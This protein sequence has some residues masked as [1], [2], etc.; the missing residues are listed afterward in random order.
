MD[1]S[2]VLKT[3]EQVK[4]DSKKRNFKQSYDLIITLKNLDLKKP[5]HTP[6]FFQELHFDIGKKKKIA[7]LVGAELKDEAS[8]VCDLVIID[9]DFPGY[10]KKKQ[11]AIAKDYDYFIAQANMMGKVAT[12]FGKVLGPRGKMPNPKAGC[13][14]PPKA[15]LKPLYDKLQRLSRISVKK[16]QMM[17]MIVGKEDMKDEEVADNIITVY[18]G[19]IHHLPNEVNNVK[20]VMLKLTMGKPVEI[21]K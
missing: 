5:E 18:N 19:L 6:D 14:V 7:A 2:E 20:A 15:S 11:K 9:D 13:V 8:K 12:T 3:I 4:K 21:K 10:D 16:A 1:K 17:Q